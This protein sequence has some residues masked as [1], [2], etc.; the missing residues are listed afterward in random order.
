MKEMKIPGTTVRQS[1]RSVQLVQSTI[2]VGGVHVD[3]GDGRGECWKPE[4]I[5]PGGDSGLR[6]RRRST[7]VGVLEFVLVVHHDRFVH[8]VRGCAKLLHDDTRDTLV[9]EQQQ[10]PDR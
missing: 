3:L 2:A 6:D 8:E 9:L 5:A 10:S 7:T 1:L 4:R